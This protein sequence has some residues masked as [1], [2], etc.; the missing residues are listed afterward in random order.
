MS[1]YLFAT[2]IIWL[3]GAA[4]DLNAK[5]GEPLGEV[6]R[7]SVLAASCLIKLGIG[8]WALW[9]LVQELAA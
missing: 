6:P 5:P 8:C 1:A 3:L 7:K 4:N 9:L 2:A